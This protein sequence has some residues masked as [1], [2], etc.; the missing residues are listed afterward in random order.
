MDLQGSCSLVTCVLVV[1]CITVMVTQSC[2][3]QRRGSSTEAKRRNSRALRKKG[4]FLPKKKVVKIDIQDDTYIFTTICF[5]AYNISTFR[6]L[7]FL[8][9]KSFKIWFY[10]YNLSL[11]HVIKLKK[12]R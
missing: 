12:A 1:V 9:A 10:M 11:N 4:L 7:A 3:A 2:R 6:G 5:V 8:V